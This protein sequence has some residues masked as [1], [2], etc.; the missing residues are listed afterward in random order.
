MKKASTQSFMQSMRGMDEFVLGTAHLL[1]P[2]QA[3]ALHRRSETVTWYAIPGPA[4]GV[5]ARAHTG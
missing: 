5:I 4:G 1:T 3:A 2:Q